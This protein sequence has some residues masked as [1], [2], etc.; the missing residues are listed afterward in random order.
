MNRGGVAA[1]SLLLTLG[2]TGAVA[3][4]RS[5]SADNL[6]VNQG[7][8][9]RVVDGDTIVIRI[10]GKSESVRLIGIDTPETVKPG[11]P[12]D[13]FGPEASAYTKSLLHEGDIVTVNR[14]VEARDKYHRLLGY[15][16]RA[17]DQL[18]INMDLVSSGM[19]RAKRYPPNTAMANQ[20]EAAEALANK[21][22]IGLWG[23]CANT[24]E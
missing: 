14:D 10:G 4:L 13:C 15:I 12:V 1:A 17:R 24:S 23:S 8:V 18:F 16:Y 2:A 6:A 19:A 20:F 5:D 7:V 3:Y 22:N 21:N 9:E 11:A